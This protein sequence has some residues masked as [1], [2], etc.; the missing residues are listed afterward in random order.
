MI[1]CFNTANDLTDIGLAQQIIRLCLEFG[2]DLNKLVGIGFDGGS[3]MSGLYI[4]TQAEIQKQ[5]P[6][7]FYMYCALHC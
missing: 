5:Y 1:L 7:A 4:G 6:L 2:L 3:S